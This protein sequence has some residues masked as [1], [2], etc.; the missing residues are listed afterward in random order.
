VDST[1]GQIAVQSVPVVAVT[2]I[3]GAQNVRPFAAERGQR[4]LRTAGFHQ[5]AF[6]AHAVGRM[7]QKE[8]AAIARYPDAPVG[9]ARVNGIARRPDRRNLRAAKL[10]GQCGR[11]A[12]DQGGFAF[13]LGRAYRI[14]DRLTMG[15]LECAEV[16]HLNANTGRSAG[17]GDD[18]AD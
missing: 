3:R 12:L 10:I 14:P 1:I 17:R 18:P 5:D 8:G 4:N 9:R 13:E 15:Q 6:H 2:E 16:I 11:G 7:I